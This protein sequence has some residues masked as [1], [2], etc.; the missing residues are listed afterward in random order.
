MGSSSGTLH[1]E[2]TAEEPTAAVP[3]EDRGDTLETGIAPDGTP[4]RF[5]NHP[6][7]NSNYWYMV[8]TDDDGTIIREHAD[9]IEP[10]GES[11]TEKRTTGGAAE[12]AQAQ[13]TAKIDQHIHARL[14]LAGRHRDAAEF[15]AKHGVRIPRPRQRRTP[16]TRFARRSVRAARRHAGSTTR[17]RT[18]SS[19]DPEPPH[20]RLTGSL[21]P[22]PI[23]GAR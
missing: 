5:K 20:A 10:D 3:T 4:F 9:G 17:S 6:G 12:A 11:T 21:A 18:S 22:A 14:I 23:G 8:G 16:M 7:P 15:A 1:T 19:S 13:I 2:A